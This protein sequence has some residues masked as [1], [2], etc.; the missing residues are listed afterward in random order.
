MP[1]SKKGRISGTK[2]Q[3]I[4]EQR[5][6]AAISG[7][8]DGIAFARVTKMLGQAHV[9]VA[10]EYKHG[11]KE[12]N[13]RIPNVLGRRGAT[14]ITTNDI[15]AIEVGIGYDPDTP[16]SP[17]EHFDIKTILTKKQAYKLKEDGLIPDWM[18]NDIDGDKSADAKDGGFEFDYNETKGEDDDSDEDEEEDAALREKLGAKRITARD[19]KYDDNADEINI[20]EI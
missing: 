4:N 11:M 1:K 2:R 19:T 14:P 3:E 8:L 20:D 12:L 7:R 6:A 10:I 5:A 18:V 17:G 9:K 13:A 15:V 16:S